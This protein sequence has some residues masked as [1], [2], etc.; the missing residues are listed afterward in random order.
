MGGYTAVEYCGGPA[1]LFKMGRVDVQKV[2]DIDKSAEDG[3]ALVITN[4]R[5]TIK[6]KFT[7]MGFNNRELVALMGQNTIGFAHSGFEGR[8]T[9]NPYVFDN[10]YYKEVLLGDRSKYLKTEGE[11]LLHDDQ[12]L[13]EIC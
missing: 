1:M 3:K 13:N 8:W 11:W 9:M 2:G 10:T 5:F 12:E 4:D 7:R 6:D